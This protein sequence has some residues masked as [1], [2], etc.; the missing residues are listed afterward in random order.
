ML[1]NI[2]SKNW[3]KKPVCEAF[4][5]SSNFPKRRWDQ[6]LGDFKRFLHI[7]AQIFYSCLVLYIHGQMRCHSLSTP[8]PIKIPLILF[9][10]AVLRYVVDWE[11][12]HITMPWQLLDPKKLKTKLRTF[13]P[14][15][16]QTNFT[17]SSKR[18]C[19]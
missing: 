9:Y 16:S 8:T 13:Q 7:E 3:S 15:T 5:A 6:R 11:I 1:Q 17:G 2:E 18:E 4:Q 12:F 19:C 10:T 14:Q